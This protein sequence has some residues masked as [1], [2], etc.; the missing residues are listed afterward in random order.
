MGK[1]LVVF[2]KKLVPQALWSRSLS[3]LKTIPSNSASSGQEIA[4]KRAARNADAER[5]RLK[6]MGLGVVK[7]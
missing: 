3:Y 4:D 5:K 1:K 7:N 6:S 2:S